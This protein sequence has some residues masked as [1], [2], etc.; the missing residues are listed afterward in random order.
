MFTSVEIPANS[1]HSWTFVHE[2]NEYPLSI[3][4]HYITG[5]IIGYGQSEEPAIFYVRPFM[6]APGLGAFLSFPEVFV[7]FESI[8][9][10]P[11]Y[12][13]TDSLITRAQFTVEFDSNVVKIK[14]VEIGSG[15]APESVVPNFEITGIEQ[16]PSFVPTHPAANKNILVQI[17]GVDPSYF[18]SGHQV[19]VLN[20]E[21]SIIGMPGDST[22]LAFDPRAD[23]TFL[24][25]TCYDTLRG[26]DLVYQYGSIDIIQKGG[27]V[28]IAGKT[29][30]WSYYKPVSNVTITLRFLKVDPSPRPP[31]FK[32]TDRFGEFLFHGIPSNSKIIIHTLKENDW[33]KSITGDDAILILKYLA[34]LVEFSDDQSITADVDKDGNVTAEDALAILRF[35]ARTPSAGAAGTWVFDPDSI[36]SQL[37]E[38]PTLPHFDFLSYLLGDVSGDWGF[39]PPPP[40]SIFA[41]Q[42]SNRLEFGQI[43]IDSL[44]RIC[45]PIMVRIQEGAPQ[46]I[47]FNIEYDSTKTKYAGCR[48]SEATQDFL[49]A[50]N[51]IKSGS[52]R[53]SLASVDENDR[54]IELL[55][56]FFNQFVSPIDI[57]DISFRMN[58]IVIGNNVIPGEIVTS[59]NSSY[60]SNLPENLC[61]EQN[62]P[63][64]FNAATKIDYALPAKIGEHNLV[65]LEIFSV[66]G[67]LIKTL[68]HSPQLLGLYSVTWDGT[69]NSGAVAP[70]GLYLYRLKVGSFSKASKLMLIR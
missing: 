57:N 27:G 33:R 20:F 4:A 2:N 64:P 17:A 53:F 3:G 55:T 19:E 15:L 50:S 31:I 36:V 67:R 62:Y 43:T 28:S 8:V 65:K 21:F 34:T 22:I 59:V 40:P 60:E 29:A 30:F 23:H 37:D 58:D 51:T 24:V 39:H 12:V 35:V 42:D 9:N 44:N 46:A 47:S 45:V 6:P 16:N 69:T 1:S 68:V 38:E 18:F 70:S 63:N 61:L 13:S 56:C 25:T 14:N 7:E 52:S 66:D 48:L 41:L 26:K 11:L 54:H 10:M 32:D 5:N 49:V